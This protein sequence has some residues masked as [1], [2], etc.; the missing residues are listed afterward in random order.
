MISFNFTRVLLAA[1]KELS[2]NALAPMSS[3]LRDHDSVNY[4]MLSNKDEV[5]PVSLKNKRPQQS[6]EPI[7]NRESPVPL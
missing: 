2:G 6:P 5:F 3:K 7:A 4:S 1:T